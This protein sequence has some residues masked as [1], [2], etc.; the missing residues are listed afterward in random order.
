[1][2]LSRLGALVQRVIGGRDDDPDKIRLGILGAMQQCVPLIEAGAEVRLV[3][4]RKGG[5]VVCRVVLR[6]GEHN[7]PTLF[8]GQGRDKGLAASIAYVMVGSVVGHTKGTQWAAAA[9]RLYDGVEAS[10]RAEGL[11]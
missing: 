8:E 9:Q 4:L 2:K 10:L 6:Q 11:L 7:T 5:D 1:M 3:W